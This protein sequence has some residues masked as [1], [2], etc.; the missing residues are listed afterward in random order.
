[1]AK[2]AANFDYAVSWVLLEID[3]S[4]HKKIYEKRKTSIGSK[5][6]LSFNTENPQSETLSHETEINSQRRETVM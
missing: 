1:M 4:C 3:Y 6:R 5:A 2:N